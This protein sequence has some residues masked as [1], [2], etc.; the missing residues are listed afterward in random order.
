[1]SVLVLGIGNL[2]MSDDAV[3]VMVAQ[4]SSEEVPVCG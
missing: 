3:G 4:T 1:M 2:V